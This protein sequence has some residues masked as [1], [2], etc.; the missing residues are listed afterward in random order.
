V[1]YIATATAGFDHIDTQY[2]ENNGIKW[3]NAPAC[4]ALAVTQYMASVF[5]HFTRHSFFNPKEKTVGIV[6]VGAVGSRVA[7][8][9]KQ[10]G[11]NVLLNDPPRARIEGNNGFVSLDEICKNSDIITF[12]TPLTMDGIDKTYHLA[13]KDFFDKLKRKPILINTA[14]GGIIDSNSLTK[15]V[16]VRKLGHL[17]IDCWENEPE[18]DKTL[19]SLCTL[20]TPHIAGYSADAKANATQQCV[21]AVSKQF[22][23]YKDSW[24]AGELP[25]PATLP[26]LLKMRPGYF[27]LKTFDIERESR[28]F[29]SQPG[30]FEYHRDL[31]KLRREPK[32]YF[33]Y[34]NQDLIN[35][36]GDFWNE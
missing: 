20:A 33:E 27:Y 32:A 19:L 25:A 36:L 5:S 21:R 15:Y 34:I 24:E 18:I 35:K 31:T 4:N 10:M 1:R 23:L 8:L 29:K 6:G 16:K 17:V 9:A 7:K 13:G 26:K 14:R 11:F 2:C 3:T 28:I 30:L 12:H 22:H